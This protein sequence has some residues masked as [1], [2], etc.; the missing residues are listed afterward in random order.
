MEQ[1]HSVL[2]VV[3]R[4]EGI[5]TDHFGKFAGLVGKGFDR[6]PHFVNDHVEARVRGLPRG[7]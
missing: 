1:A 2:F 6:G 7:L 3:V 5:R 4:A